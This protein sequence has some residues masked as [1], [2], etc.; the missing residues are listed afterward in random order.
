MTCGFFQQSGKCDQVDGNISPEAVCDK[1]SM[2]E[3][4]PEIKH[5]EFYQDEYKKANA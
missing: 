5:A 3:K 4:L 1:Y 2:K